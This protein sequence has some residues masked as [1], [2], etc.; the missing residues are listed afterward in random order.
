MFCFFLHLEGSQFVTL[1]YWIQ[2]TQRNFFSNYPRITELVEV[3]RNLLSSFL[4]PLLRVR[5][6]SIGNCH[7]MVFAT[8]VQ[9][10]FLPKNLKISPG[11]R[12]EWAVKRALSS[13]AMCDAERD[14]VEKK[15]GISPRR[16]DSRKSGLA[17][18]SENHE[19]IL[20]LEDD[21]DDEVLQ[22][23][24]FKEA[25]PFEVKEFLSVLQRLR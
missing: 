15:D 25:Q 13:W 10:G 23:A 1:W 20:S 5:T 21:V 11:R 4:A 6:L 12:K 8:I 24:M 7:I 19:T 9:C 18:R 14:W 2:N 3:L 16:G 22:D 17:R